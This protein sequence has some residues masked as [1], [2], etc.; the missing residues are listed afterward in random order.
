MVIIKG[1]FSN[2]SFW[3]IS[4]TWKACFQGICL[5]SHD[6]ERTFG[7]GRRVILY[8]WIKEILSVLHNKVVLGTEI[9][10]LLFSL[11]QKLEVNNLWCGEKRVKQMHCLDCRER[12]YWLFRFQ[13]DVKNIFYFLYGAKW[14]FHFQT[15]SCWNKKL[16]TRSLEQIIDCCLMWF[17][18]LQYWN[19]SSYSSLLLSFQQ[20]SLSLWH[21][22]SHSC[23]REKSTLLGLKGCAFL[24]VFIK[25]Y[26]NSCIL[27]NVAL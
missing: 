8:Y 20:T 7:L 15:M 24:D 4:W 19:R 25:P 6:F 18:R 9:L 14:V 3:G 16:L 23:F 13:G 22:A 10:L 21:K 11:I 27:K 1:F 26:L 2:K 17:S 5:F 12:Q